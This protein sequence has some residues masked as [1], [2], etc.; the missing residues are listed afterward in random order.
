MN[1]ISAGDGISRRATG[2]LARRGTCGRNVPSKGREV[3]ATSVV[4][5]ICT[6]G[7]GLVGGRGETSEGKVVRGGHGL[8]AMGAGRET[9]E[10]VGC[11]QAK[12]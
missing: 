1:L 11:E 8:Y 10:G 12:P 7:T 5:R 4:G 9:V 3:E 2:L 6:V